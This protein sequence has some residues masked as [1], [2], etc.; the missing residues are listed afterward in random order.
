MYRDV[1]W[2]C[3]ILVQ[4]LNGDVLDY[5]QMKYYLVNGYLHVNEWVNNVK[6]RNQLV[7]AYNYCVKS[8]I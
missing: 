3:N 6:R 1:T 8:K 2:F 7:F 5:Y 4:E